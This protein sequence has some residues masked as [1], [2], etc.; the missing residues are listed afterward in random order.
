MEL[1]LWVIY[2]KFQ[3]AKYANAVTKFLPSVQTIISQWM[4]IIIQVA[5]I[6]FW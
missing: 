4:T 2:S 6:F 1:C 3:L 5:K